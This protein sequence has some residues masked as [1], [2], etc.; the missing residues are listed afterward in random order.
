HGGFILKI[1]RILAGQVFLRN[2]DVM[3]LAS[4]PSQAAILEQT[5]V[6]RVI[7]TKEVA[8]SEGA[9]V[10]LP[11]HIYPP[12]S[13]SSSTS[14]AIICRQLDGALGFPSLP[15]VVSG[16]SE[17]RCRLASQIRSVLDLIH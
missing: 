9:H 11:P 12:T 14:Y 17:R 16:G 1:V 8:F 2:G 13:A 10:T 7:P 6:I 15:R 3:I 4:R 5:F